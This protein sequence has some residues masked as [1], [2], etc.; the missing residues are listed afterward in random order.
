MNLEQIDTSTTAGKGLIDAARAALPFIAYAFDQGIDGAEE[1]GRAIEDAL[2]DEQLQGYVLVPVEP[3]ELQWGGLARDIVMWMECYQTRSA[4]SLLKHLRRCGTEIPKWLMDE[5]KGGS[6]SIDKG[7]VA[8]I[9]YKAMIYSLS[10]A[11]NVND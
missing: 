6:H 2:R 11:P 7:T 1:A 10:K 8:A 3:T 4:D 9:I 5:A